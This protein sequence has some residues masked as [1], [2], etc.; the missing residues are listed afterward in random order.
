MEETEN[1]VRGREHVSS[2]DS[3]HPITGSADHPIHDVVQKHRQLRPIA[4]TIES[5][6]TFTLPIGPQLTWTAATQAIFAAWLPLSFTRIVVV[7]SAGKSGTRVSQTAR[8]SL[9]RKPRFLLNHRPFAGRSKTYRVA[10]NELG[11]TGR[12][13]ISYRLARQEKSPAWDSSM[14]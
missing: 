9:G 7:A 1:T 4:P 3:D 5:V 2:I 6:P 8:T 10:L 11:R 13:I 14:D 12:H